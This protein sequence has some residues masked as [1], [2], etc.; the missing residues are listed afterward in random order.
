MITE[1]AFRLHMNVLT[2]VVD[3]MLAQVGATLRQ[4][5]AD[6]D[7]A[8][9]ELAVLLATAVMIACRTKGISPADFM[10]MAAD[11]CEAGTKT[12]DQLREAVK[13]VTPDTKH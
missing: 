7:A 13:L 10:A 9:M 1:Q 11:A 5:M 12:P 3:A 6:D 2:K 8:R 4:D